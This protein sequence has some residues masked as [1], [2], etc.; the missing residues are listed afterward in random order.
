MD[1]F[2]AFPGIEAVG[3]NSNLHLNPL[4]QSSSDVNVDGFEPPTDHGAFIADRAEVEPE[5]LEAAGIEIVRKAQLQRR[6]PAGH[7]AR[8]HRQ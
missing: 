7:P 8:G 2:R 3:A 1:P 6:R 5:F 4:S